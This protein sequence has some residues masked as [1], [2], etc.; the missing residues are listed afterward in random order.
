M[1]LR[2]PVVERVGVHLFLIFYWQRLI[3]VSGVWVLMCT[4]QYPDELR[5]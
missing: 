2:H 1:A 5:N 3:A 4:T